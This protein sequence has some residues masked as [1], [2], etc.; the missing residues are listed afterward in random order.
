MRISTIRWRR[1]RIRR[2]CF[3][4]LYA[5]VADVRPHRTSMPSPAVFLPKA[6]SMTSYG[7]LADDFYVNLNLNTEMKLPDGRETILEFFQRVQKSFPTMRNFYTRDNG[8]FVL[9]EDK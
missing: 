4:L 2:R 9:E 7:S 5:G 1:R 8:D 6:E 3:K